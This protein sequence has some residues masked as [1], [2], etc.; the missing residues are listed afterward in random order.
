M[1]RFSCRNCVL[2]GKVT[3]RDYNYRLPH[4]SLLAEA[5]V[6]PAGHGIDVRYGDHFRTPEEGGWLA[7][8]RAE[9]LLCERETY[10]GA[11]DCLAF[12]AGHLFTLDHHYRNE[13]NREYLLV[14]VR[15]AGGQ[16]VPGLDL[17]G[18]AGGTLGYRNEFEAIDG[19]LTYRPPLRTPKPV[20]PGIINAH[21][22][23]EGPGTRAEIDEDGRYKVVLPFD[24]SRNAGGKAS[25]F[26][27]KAE[28]YG[29]A[30]GGMHFPLLK[31]TEVLLACVD[32]DPD[33]PVILG[34]VPNPRTRSVSNN[35]TRDRNR[36]VTTSG[37]LMEFADGLVDAE[38]GAEVATE[39]AALA[40][41]QQN[42]SVAADLET[43]LPPLPPAI[44][45]AGPGDPRANWWRL[46]VPHA[47][48]GDGGG[49]RSYL[50]LGMPPRA[51]L[52][53][54]GSVEP[55]L[56]DAM[57]EP[58]RDSTGF[59]PAWRSDGPEGLLMFTEGDRAGFAGRSSFDAV[60]GDARRHVGGGDWL[61]VDG[62]G[63]TRVGGSATIIV[64]KSRRA[65]VGTAGAPPADADTLL[66]HGNRAVTV[67][68]TETR[69]VKG[70]KS[71]KVDGSKSTLVKGEKKDTY[72]GATRV[73]NKGY[74]T[75]IYAA[76]KASIS[77]SQSV[78][79][80]FAHK[81]EASF[82]SSQ[83]LKVGVMDFTFAAGIDFKINASISFGLELGSGIK[84]TPAELKVS[85]LG[86]EVKKKELIVKAK[87]AK[88]EITETA[89]VEVATNKTIM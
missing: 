59:E 76:G 74:S 58:T 77:F 19:S 87:K 70:N 42:Q 21:V 29:G 17:G 41:Q 83:T 60:R 36:I 52:E 49:L 34:A 18:P 85:L 48:G 2:P 23:A 63:E 1:H 79:L 37:I 9:Q 39:G 26:M 22:D 53:P 45:R 32:G 43:V 80:S 14:R 61:W 65:E 25:R 81:L 64:A 75:E 73:L 8:L 40:P 71:E 4:V 30:R 54:S 20:M 12:S 10:E 28:P 15:H 3:L 31:D 44:G 27:R 51:S 68:G 35:V 86:V 84:I 56:R 47:K 66:V 5:P 50:R 57:I 72:I 62:N 38:E 11:G 46:Y 89:D 33:R 24:L 13:F 6:D 69:T 7:K 67:S 78:G 16:T 55:A 88:V 82:S